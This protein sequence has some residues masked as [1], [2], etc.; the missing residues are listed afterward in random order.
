VGTSRSAHAQ[1]AFGYPIDGLYI[2]VAGQFSLKGKESA[3]SFSHGSGVTASGLG[4]ST[5]PVAPSSSWGPMFNVGYDLVDVAS[6]V[7]P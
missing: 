2:G 3:N 1:Q 4:A 6:W 7:I 5:S